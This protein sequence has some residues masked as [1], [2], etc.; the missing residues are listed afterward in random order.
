[1]NRKKLGLFLVV[2][3]VLC[4]LVTA[5]NKKQEPITIEDKEM[6]QLKQSYDQIHK[7]VATDISIGGRTCYDV[8]EYKDGIYNSLINMK[9]IK[10]TYEH[11]TDTGIYYHFILKDKSILSFGFNLGH[12]EKRN[13]YYINKKPNYKIEYEKEVDCDLW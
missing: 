10:E 2:M 11:G 9:L 3:L 13:K 1:M 5:C 6:D 7:V 4:C 12:Y 8:T